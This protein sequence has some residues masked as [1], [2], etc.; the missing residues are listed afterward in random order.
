MVPTDGHFLPYDRTKPGSD[1]KSPTNG[2]IFVLGFQSSTQK[3]VFWLQSKSQHPSGDPSWFSPRDLKLGYIV[4]QL[5]QGEEINVQEEVANISNDQA[6]QGDEPDHMDIDHTEPERQ[7]DPAESHGG[8]GEGTSSDRG[9][10]S[11]QS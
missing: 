9:T 6:G 11:G 2:R 7:S 4:D 10:S 5:L 3:H 8:N 1:Q